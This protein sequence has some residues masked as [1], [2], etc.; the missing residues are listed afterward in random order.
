MF[1]RVALLLIVNTFLF[2]SCKNEPEVKA[3]EPSERKEMEREREREKAMKEKMPDPISP[4]RVS[5]KII[6]DK[7][8]GGYGYDIYLDGKLTYHQPHIPAVNGLKGFYSK[9]EAERVAGFIIYK[10][11]HNIMPPTLNVSELDSMHIRYN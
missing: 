11:T 9:E 4:D 3:N 7:Q 1:K 10:I 2:L 6:Q 8:Y 5:F